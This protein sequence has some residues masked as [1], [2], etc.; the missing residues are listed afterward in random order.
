MAQLH[1]LLSESLELL[2]LSGQLPSVLGY[3]V[4]LEL[5][6]E[7]AADEGIWPSQEREVEVATLRDAWLAKR[8]PEATGLN[9]E[10]L[11]CKLSVQPGSLRWARFHWHQRLDSLF[12]ARKAELDKASCRLLR[13]SDKFLAQELY[14]RVLAKEASFEELAARFGEGPERS[15]AGLIPMQS[16]SGMPLGLEKVLPSLSPGEVTSPQRLGNGFALVQL[17]QWQPVSRDAD[18]DR[19]LLKHELQ[20]WVRA[21]VRHLQHHLGLSQVVSSP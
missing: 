18:I 5:S 21:V 6:R 19:V 1:R 12:L 7:A 17:L 10:Q 9:E 20:A 8:D 16:L 13:L 14:Y 11:V 15:Q 4:R 2:A 3:W